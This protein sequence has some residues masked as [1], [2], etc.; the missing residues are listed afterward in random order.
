MS[1]MKGCESS[2]EQF[3]LWNSK[4]IY[5]T[6]KFNVE[7]ATTSESRNEWLKKTNITCWHHELSL[8]LKPIMFT[9]GP[10]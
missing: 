6:I 9:L 10:T 5:E 8:K 2:E 1:I 3:G 7:T 4:C